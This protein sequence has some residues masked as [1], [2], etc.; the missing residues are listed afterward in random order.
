MSISRKNPR[1]L[2]LMRYAGGI[3]ADCIELVR[4][5]IVPGVT[6][7]ELD[8]LA[9]D[10]IRKERCHAPCLGYHGYPACSCLSVNDQVVH[11]IPGSRVLREGDII[12]VDITVSWRGYCA[13]MARTFPVGMI[14][15]NAQRLIQITEECFDEA[16]RVLLVDNTIGDV[17]AAV[18]KHA[19]SNG[20]SPVRALCGHGI[21]SEMHEEPEVPNFGR[22]HEGPVLQPGMTLAVEPMINEGKHGVTVADDGW[23]V[24]TA[25]HRLSAHHENTIVITPEGPVVLTRPREENHGL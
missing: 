21:G 15:P 22:A 19:K 4:R 20:Y 25:D 7:R 6:T 23:T 17:S 2:E 12:G 18:E 5:H 13:D 14:K 11:G 1:E 16:M 9:E 24:S 10:F 3:V 8:A